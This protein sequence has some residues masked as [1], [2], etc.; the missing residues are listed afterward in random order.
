[1]H[2]GVSDV[3][4]KVLDTWDLPQTCIATEMVLKLFDPSA[5]M[6]SVAFPAYVSSCN[7]IY[8]CPTSS[9]QQTVQPH[10]LPNHTPFAFLLQSLTYVC[11]LL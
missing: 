5:E 3:L 6:H 1:M 8:I 7:L 2:E 11:L 9:I 4:L 10:F